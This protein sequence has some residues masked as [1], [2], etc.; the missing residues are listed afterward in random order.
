M[1]SESSC[2]KQVKL[3]DGSLQVVS[4]KNVEVILS[5]EPV[6][7]KL[8]RGVKREPKAGVT[9]FCICDFRQQILRIQ[10]EISD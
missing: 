6:L 5:D 7:F 9:F 4:L 1:P 10:H 8:K 3:A 2:A